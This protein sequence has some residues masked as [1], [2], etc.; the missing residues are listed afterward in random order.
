MN[1]TGKFNP[2]HH[3]LLDSEQRKEMLPPKLIMEI[4]GVEDKMTLVDIGAGTGNLLFPALSYIG[5]TGKIYGL[6]IYDKMIE[7]LK[8]KVY[9]RDTDNV[10]IIKNNTEK[11]PLK[12]NVSDITYSCTV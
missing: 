1:E 11:F 7:I 9:E 3:K 12:D 8:Q 4:M 6:D 10:L 2:K 5:E